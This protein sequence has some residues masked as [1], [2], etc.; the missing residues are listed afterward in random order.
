MKIRSGCC[1]LLV[2]LTLCLQF[3][4]SYTVA[5]EED[6]GFDTSN[7]SCLINGN[8]P[9]AIEKISRTSSDETWQ[10]ATDASALNITK[11]HYSYIGKVFSITGTVYKIERLPQTPARKG[12]WSE[13]LMSAQN[14]N[15]PAGVTTIDVLFNGD[16]SNINPKS[17]IKVAGYYIG[18]VESMNLLGGS[19]ECLVFVANALQIDIPKISPKG[20]K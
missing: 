20:R 4:C 18:T 7:K 9:K 17:R 2:I 8:M 15:S 5:A 3:L 12:N 1:H 6:P 19:V 10:S 11:D 13:I 14:R 16:I